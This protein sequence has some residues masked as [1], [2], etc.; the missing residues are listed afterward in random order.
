MLETNN[1]IGS[2]KLHQPIQPKPHWF[3]FVWF[4]FY[5]KTKM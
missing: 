3:R 1:C 5:F 2:K 4:E